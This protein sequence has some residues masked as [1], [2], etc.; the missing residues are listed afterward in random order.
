MDVKLVGPLLKA[1]LTKQSDINVQAGV[2]DLIAFIKDM[3]RLLPGELAII[4]NNPLED[5]LLDFC[6]AFTSK[7]GKDKSVNIVEIADKLTSQSPNTG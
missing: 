2:F 6:T 3:A 5:G 4:S 1:V 7:H